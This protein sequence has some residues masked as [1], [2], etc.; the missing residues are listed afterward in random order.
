MPDIQSRPYK[1]NPD[2]CCERCVFTTG[3]HAP[4]C[5]SLGHQLDIAF[6]QL[7]QTAQKLNR[8]YDRMFRK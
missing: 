1:P 2:V 3:E 4:W 6:E 5:Q 8:E 7:R